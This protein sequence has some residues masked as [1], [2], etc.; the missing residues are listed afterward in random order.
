MEHVKIRRAVAFGVKEWA[1]RK[2]GDNMQSPMFKRAI[3]AKNEERI[4]I[5]PALNN[6]WYA[7]KYESIQP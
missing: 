6:A 2:F 5:K 3:V 1:A 4:R 7:P